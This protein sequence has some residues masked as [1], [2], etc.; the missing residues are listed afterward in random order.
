[1][2]LLRLVSFEKDIFICPD[3]KF[4]FAKLNEMRSED[5]SALCNCYFINYD[6]SEETQ[7]F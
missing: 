7:L 1:M 6:R 3:V 5:A 4:K 2:D